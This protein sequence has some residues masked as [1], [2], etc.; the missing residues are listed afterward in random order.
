V[1]NGHDF[2][3]CCRSPEIASALTLQP[4]DR[5]DGLVD[6]AIIFSD[7]LVIPQAMGMEVVMVDKKGPH[8]P[9]PLQ[10]PEDKQ[11]KEILERE[12]DVEKSLDYVYK[13]ITMTRHKLAGRVPL[14]GF[15]G[16]PCYATWSKVEAARCSFRP[17]RGSTSTRSR[18]K[19]YFRRLQS[20]AWNTWH[21]KYRLARR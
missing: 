9:E 13:A 14:I 20:F 3:E 19:R 4:I 12:V 18:A 10:T 16:A 1:K 17:R 15:C 5:F 2:F 6:A 11:Y 7:I 21:S 8:F